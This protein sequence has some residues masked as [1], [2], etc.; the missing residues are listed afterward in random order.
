LTHGSLFAGIGGFDLGFER[1]GIKTVWQVE[2]GP[3]CRKVLERHWPNVERFNDV[4]ECG[5]DNLSRVD[6]VTGGF[7]CQDIS[8]AGERAG[9]EGSRSGLWSEMWRIICDLRPQFVVVENVS[10][11]LE[12]G[13]ERVL[14]DLALGGF[15]AEW[16]VLSACQ[17]GAPHTRERVFIVAYPT[18]YGLEGA[19]RSEE[20]GERLDAWQAPETAPTPLRLGIWGNG[21]RSFAGMAHRVPNRMERLRGHGNVVIPQIAEWIG[22]RIVEIA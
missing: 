6:V 2:I 1:A 8:Q 19:G 20:D 3:F 22:R 15:D 21:T 12:R 17:F 11:L 10:A 5:A 4:K 13:M 18:G 9:I 16:R 14:H 7:P